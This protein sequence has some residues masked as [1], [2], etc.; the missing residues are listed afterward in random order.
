MPFIKL[1][2]IEKWVKKNSDN[3]IRLYVHCSR[4]IV[5]II[6]SNNTLNNTMFFPL[7][8]NNRMLPIFCNFVTVMYVDG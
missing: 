5:G 1:F 6:L 8:C 2:V 4:S 3:E 7:L